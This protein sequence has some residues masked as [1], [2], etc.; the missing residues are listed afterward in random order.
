MKRSLSSHSAA[1]W[2]VALA[3]VFMAICSCDQ[4]T[5]YAEYRHTYLAGWD[6]SDTLVYDIAP[7]EQMGDYMEELG[8]R[9]NGDYPFRE[10]CVIVEQTI[11]PSNVL[12][13][14][15]LIINVMEV[16]GMPRGRGVNSFQYNAPI[17]SVRLAENDSLHVVVHHNMRRESLPGVS[18]VGL[19]ISK[20]G[21]QK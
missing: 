4:T 16:N 12:R 21:Y 9:I 11:I 10:I 15:T 5:V 18:E 17:G 7:M 13:V 20:T 3:I 2:L 1:I 6:R 19:K 14:D 8:L